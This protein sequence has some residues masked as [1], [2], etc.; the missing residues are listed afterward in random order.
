MR[1][2]LR[3]VAAI[4]FIFSSA[5]SSLFAD[6]APYLGEWQVDVPATFEAGKESPKYN[7]ADDERMKPMISKMLQSMSLTITSDTLTLSRGGKIAQTLTYALKST[8]DGT[9]TVSVTMDE[10]T[11]DFT[12]TLGAQRRMQLK[13]TGAP[14][15]DYYV[16]MPQTTPPGDAPGVA[17]IF[18][19]AMGGAVTSNKDNPTAAKPAPTI[20]GNL[21]VLL[22]AA[23]QY[24]LEM[25]TQTAPFDALVKGKYF[26]PLHIINGED[27]ST[28]IIDTENNSSS[29][30]DKNGTTYTHKQE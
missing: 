29:V 4:S 2:P 12:L 15:L 25:G 22:Q 1:I 3:L 20:E 10:D 21:R 5:T 11:H 26:K 30:T 19:G 13:S 9:T 28:A 27:Y 6:M 14:H 7:A 24:N 23:H 16:W 8:T 17:D 18:A